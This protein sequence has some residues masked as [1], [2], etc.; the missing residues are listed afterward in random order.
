MLKSGYFRRDRLEIAR[1]VPEVTDAYPLFC[2][3]Q[4]FRNPENGVK[5]SILI[6]GLDPSRKY[7]KVGGTAE[8]NERCVTVVG[9]YMLGTDFADDG[10]I[11][12]SDRTFN[13]IFYGYLPDNKGLDQADFGLIRLKKGADL[14][15]ARDELDALLPPNVL[16]LTKEEFLEREY[17][18]W[19]TATPI[20]YIF[21]LG[22][23]MGFIVGM[24]I[25]YQILFSDI[26]DHM[27]EFATLK[28]MGYRPSY[29]VRLVLQEALLLSVFGFLP[30]LIAEQLLYEV[31]TF[32]TGLQVTMSVARIGGVVLLT[33]LMCV[34]SGFLT[35]RKVVT[36]DPAELF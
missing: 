16:V 10:T 7:V 33:T 14:A 25:C 1:A 2:A 9:D 3:L 4:L 31:V 27:R 22:T 12:C 32:A 5:R 15:A 26:S 23:V 29:F 19:N 28:A 6:L 35:M 8:L 17:S 30:G 11:L 36:S 13:A 18:F 24:I 21:A 20:G 34:I